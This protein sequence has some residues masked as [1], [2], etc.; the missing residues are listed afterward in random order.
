MRVRRAVAGDISAIL[1]LVHALARHHG[2]QPR[3]TDATLFADAFGPN[4]VV[5]ILVADGAEGIIGYAALLPL[6]QLQHGARGFD[7]HHLFVAEGHRG[8]G[9]GRAMIKA[10]KDH[11][12]RTGAAYL[13]VGTTVENRAAQE[14]Y[15]AEGAEAAPV[16]TPRF[17]WSL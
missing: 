3:S 6:I 11:A 8:S 4:A 16:T 15:L 7:L 5:Q 17:R 1:P 10:A 14:Y 12:K 9:V 13:T 2:D